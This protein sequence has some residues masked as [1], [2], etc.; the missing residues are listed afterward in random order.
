MV[1]PQF[2]TAAELARAHSDGTPFAANF[3]RDG[4]L[5]WQCGP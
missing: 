1:G 5:L 4:V 3:G 2:R